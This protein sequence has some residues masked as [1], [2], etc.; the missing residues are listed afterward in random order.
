LA[1]IVTSNQECN[2]LLCGDFNARTGELDDF[3]VD[4]DDIAHVYD[5]DWYP[6]DN[7]NVKRKS[8]DKDGRINYF[9]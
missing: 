1:E 7:F 9:G 6:E 4:D 2:I 5:I 3:I 8:R